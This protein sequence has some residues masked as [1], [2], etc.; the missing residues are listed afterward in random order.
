[1]QK[2]VNPKAE[3]TYTLKVVL[4]E[5]KVRHGKVYVRVSVNGREKWIDYVESNN[6]AE[7]LK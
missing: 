2:K 4:E 5:V 1:M 3:I 6:A 7:D